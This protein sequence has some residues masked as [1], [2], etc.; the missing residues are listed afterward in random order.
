M[1]ITMARKSRE[2]GALIGPEGESCGVPADLCVEHGRIAELEGHRRQWRR[3][4]IEALDE[5]R[6]LQGLMRAILSAAERGDIEAIKIF[7][8]Q[9]GSATW[10]PEWATYAE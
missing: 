4:A 9:K 6:S 5:V 2:C 1:A 8:A 7:A 10:V 3:H